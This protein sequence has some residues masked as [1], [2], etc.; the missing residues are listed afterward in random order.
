M[1]VA[2][3]SA[4]GLYAGRVVELRQITGAQRWRI[5]V[6]TQREDGQRDSHTIRPDQKVPISALSEIVQA[7]IDELC[8]PGTKLVDAR[9]DFYVERVA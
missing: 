6:M 1:R 2:T 7:T 8:E 3:F 4:R 9:M 5:E